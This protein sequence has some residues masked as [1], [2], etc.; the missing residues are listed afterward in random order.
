MADV[1]QV[2]YNGGTPIFCPICSRPIEVKVDV[3]FSAQSVSDALVTDQGTS[4][5]VAVTT[6]IRG[7]SFQHNCRTA[8]VPEEVPNGS[9][10]E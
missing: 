10:P 8:T 2:V 6:N 7:A 4:G 3:E 9:T 1:V 5:Q